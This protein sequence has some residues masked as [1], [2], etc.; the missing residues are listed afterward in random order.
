M[1]LS[2][3]VR[4]NGP[5]QLTIDCY[6]VLI[7]FCRRFSALIPALI[8]STM[9]SVPYIFAFPNIDTM[10]TDK[11]HLFTSRTAILVPHTRA[12]PFWVRL[13][14]LHA[15][16]PFIPS[17]HT[18]GPPQLCKDSIQSATDSRTLLPLAGVFSPRFPPSSS[19][20]TCRPRRHP[21]EPTGNSLLPGGIFLRKRMPRRAIPKRLRFCVAHNSI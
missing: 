17:T 16:N 4:L 1:A 9:F 11:P 21:A 18:T 8:R 13:S 2:R 10:S 5:R 19:Q 7:A 6:L 20:Q 14:L 15:K 12:G 3:L